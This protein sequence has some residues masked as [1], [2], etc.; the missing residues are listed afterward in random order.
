MQAQRTENNVHTCISVLKRGQSSTPQ[1]IGGEVLHSSLLTNPDVCSI[2]KF[3][4][5]IYWFFFQVTQQNHE[6]MSTI[7]I[8]HLLV[9]L[10]VLTYSQTSSHGHKH[11][12]R[13]VEL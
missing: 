11:E 7:P 13:V 3:L 10:R 2:Q 9:S 1:E 12:D 4:G 8:E 6:R 5:G